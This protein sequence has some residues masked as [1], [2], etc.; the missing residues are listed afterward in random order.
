MQFAATVSSV[1][2]YR[3][4]RGNLICFAES[5]LWCLVKF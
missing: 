1:L 2:L 4:R 5:S 3:V